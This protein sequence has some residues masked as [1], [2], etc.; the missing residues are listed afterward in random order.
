MSIGTYTTI[1]KAAQGRP[2]DRDDSCYLD[3]FHVDIVFGDCVD[4]GGYRYE[5]IFVDRATRYNWVFGLK[6]LSSEA[7]LS[8]FHLFRGD[9][10]SY[11]HCFGR[12]VKQICLTLKSMSIYWI[13]IPTLLAQ[14]LVA[15]RQTNL[16]SLIGR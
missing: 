10:G 16:Q 5:L 3:I 2:I 13:V 1:V 14:L 6:D 11:A 15:N 7:I 12:T 8:A 9:A 4:P